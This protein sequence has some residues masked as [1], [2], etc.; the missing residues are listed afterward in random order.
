LE[1]RNK[2]VAESLRSALKK[3]NKGKEGGALGLRVKKEQESI[4]TW[5]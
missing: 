5:V 3:K 1:N 4:K 2:A